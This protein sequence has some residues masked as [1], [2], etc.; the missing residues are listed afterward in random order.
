[1]NQYPPGQV[2]V[3]QQ[4]GFT[5][6]ALTE[7]NTSM[8]SCCDDV[9]ICLCGLFCTVCLGCQVAGAM[10]E[11]CC[12]GTSVAMRT[13]IRTKYNIQGSI[14]NDFCTHMFCLPCSICQ[15]KREINHQQ[16]KGH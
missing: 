4:P 8:M 14:C 6:Y 12:C 7:W 9:G 15:M 13:L 10:D 5:S 1:M 11:C 16:R 2:V 3:I